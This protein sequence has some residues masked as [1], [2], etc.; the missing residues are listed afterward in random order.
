MTA[1]QQPILPGSKRGKLEVT[2]RATGD[3]RHQIFLIAGLIALD[4]AGEIDLRV[5]SRGPRI[6]DRVVVTGDTC[7]RIARPYPWSYRLDVRDP[8]SGRTVRAAVDLQD[9]KHFFSHGDL[10]SCEV[11]FKRSYDLKTA[12]VVASKYGVKVVPGGMTH[13][14]KIGEKYAKVLSAARLAGKVEALVTGP[15]RGIDA[16]GNMLFKRK[17]TAAGP[18]KKA[19]PVAHAPDDLGDFAFFQI[20]CHGNGDWKEAEQ[21]NRER[22]DLIR[23]MRASLG[24]RFQG[25]MYFD[26]PPR[27]EFADTLTN[28]PSTPQEYM[29]IVNQAA[30]GI[31]TNGFGES[32]PWKLCEYLSLGKCIVTQRP[33]FPLPTPITPGKEAVFFDTLDD[34]ARLC[35]QLLA[36]PAARQKMA[37]AAREYYANHVAPISVARRYV[38]TALE[39]IREPATGAKAAL[40]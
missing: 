14:A 12:G 28:L 3:D 40:T 29:R 7:A 27:P 36:D 35:A 24:S 11:L 1:R 17:A 10:S 18:Q 31:S 15:K 22:A 26:G 38:T 6:H 34:C 19:T 13:S 39:F 8:R 30:V 23:T 9:W 32:F 25:G 21:L 4:E 16:L 2:L 20:A 5:V 33:A 37:T